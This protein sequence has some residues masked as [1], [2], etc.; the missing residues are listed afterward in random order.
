MHLITGNKA[1]QQIV[2]VQSKTE[3]HVKRA[4]LLEFFLSLLLISF[5]PNPFTFKSYHEFL[6]MESFTFNAPSCSV[7]SFNRRYSICMMISVYIP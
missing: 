2:L 3:H 1:M 6:N 5:E 4:Q 7:E